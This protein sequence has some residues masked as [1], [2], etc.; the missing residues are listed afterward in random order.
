MTDRKRTASR[1]NDALSRADAD[2]NR[3]LDDPH[4]SP[5]EGAEADQRAWAQS[6][7]PDLLKVAGLDAPPGEPDA[8]AEIPGE[9][10][11]LDVKPGEGVDPF[12]GD[13]EWAGNED[14]RDPLEDL[15]P[16]PE[17]DADGSG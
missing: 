6:L 9:D 1:G 4:W 8:P 10:I 16:D 2:L 15:F 17:G 13:D 7:M 14:G 5:P 3:V 12:G 11:P